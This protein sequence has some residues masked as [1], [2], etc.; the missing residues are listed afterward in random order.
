[1]VEQVL[2]VPRVDLFGLT[3]NPHGFET[4]TLGRARD[5]IARFARFVDRPSAEDD[6]SLKQIIPYAVVRR[7]ARVMTLTRLSKQSEKRLHNRMSIGVGGHINPDGGMEGIVERGLKRELEEELHLPPGYAWRPVG[8]LN[9]DSTPVGSVHFGLVYVV[10]VE[11]ED[12]AVRETDLMEGGF[13]DAAELPALS[14]RME[15]WSRFLVENL[16]RVLA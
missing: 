8:C 16:G 11:T 10:D 13:R 3:H 5:R 9:D 15:T 14:E 6:P 2:V 7:G 1:M 4:K 12:V